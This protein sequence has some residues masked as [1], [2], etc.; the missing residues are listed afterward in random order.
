M[1]ILSSDISTKVKY[2]S[3]ASIDKIVGVWS[4]SYDKAT[5][6]TSRSFLNVFS[7][8]H[9]FTRPV[10]VSYLWSEDNVNWVDGG[11]FVGFNSSIA[12]SDSTNIYLAT[13]SNSGTQYYRVIAYW[14][15][16]YDG[17]N[18]SVNEYAS[19][20]KDIKYDTRVNYQKIAFQGET[21]YNS[22]TTISIPHSLGYIP[23]A[24]V[25]FE[26]ISGEVWPLN[27]GGASNPFLYDINQDEGL[28]KIYND[29]IDI[30]TF[31]VGATRRLWYTGYYDA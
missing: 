24:K 25:F 19:T 8:P 29:R 16:S 22:S 21:T 1:P 10:F 9:G 7:I 28:L 27:A 4:G 15:D 14:I 20:T 18:P 23:N 13:T 5:D 26:A 11:A 30:V 2:Y 3:G 31:S 17:T 6:T 12:F